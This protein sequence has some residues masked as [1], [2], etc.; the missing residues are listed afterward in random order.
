MAEGFLVHTTGSTWK[1]TLVLNGKA[2]GE[3]GQGA[4][5]G[6]NVLHQDG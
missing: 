6:R 5:G 2:G 4:K 3:G 1:V